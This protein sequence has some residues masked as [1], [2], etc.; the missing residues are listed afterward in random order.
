MIYEVRTYRLKPRS[1]PEFVNTFGKAYEKR[2]ALSKLAAFF[3]TEIGPL[4]EVIHIWPYKD[5]AERE[6]KRIRSAQD[7]KYAW[8]PKIGH[9]LESMQ[10]EVYVPSPMTPTFAKGNKGPIFEW[11]EYGAI[12]GKIPEIYK[13]WEKAIPKRTEMSELVM[14]MHTETGNLN[15]FVHIWAYESLE[16]RAEVRAEAAAK[17][18]WPPKGRG[19]TLQTQSNKIVLAA[20]FSPLT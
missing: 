15:K 11:R 12:P 9:L 4:N 10:S 18:I 13:N 3:V 19:E 14:A 2:Q 5:A 6:K 20:P 1:V 17:G 8:P 7:K 16:H